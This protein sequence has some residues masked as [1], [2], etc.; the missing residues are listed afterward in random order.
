MP[1]IISSSDCP[2]EKWSEP[3]QKTTQQ[4]L[5]GIVQ[6]YNSIHTHY[7]GFSFLSSNTYG[8]SNETGLN[9]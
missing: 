3:P 5:L 4:Q 1:V 7:L 6:I 8:E 2:E 9:G